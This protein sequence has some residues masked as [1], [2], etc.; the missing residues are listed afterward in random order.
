MHVSTL[1]RRSTAL[2][3][4]L[5]AASACS[6][7]PSAPRAAEQAPFD[8]AALQP[9]D[10]R[11]GIAPQLGGPNAVS[12]TENVLEITVDPNV[13][14]SYAFGQNWIYFPAHSI[15]D[16]ATS[17]YSMDLWDAPCTA[18]GTPMT[19]T[20]RWSNK[21]G[22][23]YA[24]FSPEL[25]FTPADARNISRWVIL[26]L[27][28]QKRL[29]DVD[30]YCILYDAG[31]SVGWVNEALNDPTLHAWIDRPTNSVSRRI[32]HFSGYM[33]AAGYTTGIGGLGDAS[34]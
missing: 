10:A 32:K 27:H 33:L 18:V 20:V 5:A 4:A 26:S 25:R 17:G 22:H 24:R 3:V 19:I 34:Y 30:D 9:L 21:G 6:D 11:G 14:R 7:A 29:H 31:P 23:A 2:L 28:D 8:V 16:P 12:D 13:S 15:C 1:V